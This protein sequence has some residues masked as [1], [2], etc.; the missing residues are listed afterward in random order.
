MKQG[1]EFIVI[2]ILL[3]QNDDSNSLRPTLVNTKY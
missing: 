3:K 1:E 2:T